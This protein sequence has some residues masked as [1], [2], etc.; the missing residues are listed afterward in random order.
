MARLVDLD[1]AEVGGRQS[2]RAWLTDR[3]T[4]PRSG[5]RRLQLLTPNVESDRASDILASAFVGIGTTQLFNYMH[6]EH[7]QAASQISVTPL[8][9]PHE[10]GLRVHVQY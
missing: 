6:R 8:L 7:E 5:M 10:I 3:S 9:V 2:F 1:H 4:A